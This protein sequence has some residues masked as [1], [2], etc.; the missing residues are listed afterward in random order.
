MQC[1]PLV[2]IYHR[3]GILPLI[4]NLKQ[5]LPEVTQPWYANDAGSL[6]MFAKI[7]TYFNYLKH[8]GTGRGYYPEPSKI[9]LIVHPENLEARILFDTH[10]VFKMC[11]GRR[12][13]KSYIGDDESKR[14]WLR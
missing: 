2:I 7:E 8:Q 1:D 10:H 14:N 12:Y 4:K 6:G 5:E 9:V 3:I 11:T 13:I